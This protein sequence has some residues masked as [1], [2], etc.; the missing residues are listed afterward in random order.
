MDFKDCALEEFKMDE[1]GVIEGYGSIFGTPDQGGDVVQPGAFK[2]SIKANPTVKMLW[3]HDPRDPIG[4]WDSVVE[5]GKGLRVKGRILTELARGREVLA[6]VREGIIDGLSIGYRTVR[7]GKKDGFRLIQEAQLWEVSVVTFPMHMSSRI[8]AVKAA[9]MTERDM[10]R[11]LTQ[12]ARLTRSV[13]RS[14]MAG[15][16]DAIKATQDAGDDLAKLAQFMR[17]FHQH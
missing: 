12:D 15:G 1:T 7:A 11:V 9:E 3:Q 17:E 13:A 2:A 5:D 6:M 8:D 4:K 16:F 14:L 10:E